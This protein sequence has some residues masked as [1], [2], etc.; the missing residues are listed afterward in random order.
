VNKLRIHQIIE[1]TRA[2]GPGVRLG[3]WVQGCTRNCPR[4]INPETH[5]I[6]QGDELHPT[7]VLSIILEHE[8]EIDG[9][10]ISGGEPLDQSE[11]L[12]ELLQHIK[13]KTE[14]SVILWTGYTRNELEQMKLVKRL[15]KLVDLMIIGPYI[16]EFHEPIGLK[17]S[18]NQ[19]YI[20][21]SKKY[22][23]QDLLEIPSAEIIFVGGEMQISGIDTEKI[24]RWFS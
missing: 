13:N 23:E 22:N 3:I 8:K 4:C 6:T 15:L 11:D 24:R 21:F 1:R 18:S 16:A 17:G 19:E 10:S 14:L 2:N 9:I 12:I 20:F 7:E 5:D